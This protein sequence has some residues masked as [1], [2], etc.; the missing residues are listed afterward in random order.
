MYVDVKVKEVQSM[1]ELLASLKEAIASQK[2]DESIYVQ[3]LG[4]ALEY[5]EK[6]SLLLKHK[7]YV[8]KKFSY[9]E[10][11]FSIV[12]IKGNVEY[13]NTVFL[14]ELLAGNL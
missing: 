10:V 1:D 8:V 3:G 2:E 14:K 11:T 7:F 6:D 9:E 12:Y 5:V 13:A 4:G